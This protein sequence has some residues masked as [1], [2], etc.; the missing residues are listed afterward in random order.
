MASRGAPYSVGNILIA[1]ATFASDSGH[2][3]NALI[4][5]N[6]SFGVHDKAVKNFSGDALKKTRDVVIAII[7]ARYASNGETKAYFAGGSTGGREA[8]A[9]AQKWQQ[10][11]DGV[12]TLCPA[13]AAASLDL[14]FGRIT[15]AR[16]LAPI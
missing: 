2:Q 4:S 8:L 6:G 9:A 3:A 13:G 11:W 1:N 14:Q 10:D 7:N 15:R 5:Q 16:S 12:I